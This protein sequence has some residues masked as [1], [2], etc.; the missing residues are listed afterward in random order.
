[1]KK[2]NKQSFEGYL[3][4]LEE[5]VEKLES[6]DI[7][8]EQAIL[9]YEKGMELLELCRKTLKKSKLKIEELKKRAEKTE[10]EDEDEETEE[11]EDEET[12]DDETEDDDDDKKGLF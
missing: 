10:D 11:T 8:L 12:E 6:G 2:Q 7:D 9:E 4:E 5:I 3:V 1:M